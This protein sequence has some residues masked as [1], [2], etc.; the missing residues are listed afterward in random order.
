M[1]PHNVILSELVKMHLMQ[2]HP[3]GENLCDMLN[4]NGGGGFDLEN[5]HIVLEASRTFQF[6]S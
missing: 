2:E 1:F 3:K 5:P 6:F 4:G